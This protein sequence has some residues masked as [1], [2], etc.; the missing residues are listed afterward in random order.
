MPP[1]YLFDMTPVDLEH[2]RY[3]LAEVEKVNP[4]RGDMRLLD[5]VAW[6]SDEEP[7]GVAWKDVGEDE[8][9]V[10]G[11]IPGRPLF[12]GVL[13]LEAAAQLASFVCLSWYPE[14]TFMGFAGATDVKFRG[15]V[16]P[17]DRLILLGRQ[18]E[19]RHRRILCKTQGWVKG[20]L[21]FQADITGAPM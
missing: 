16:L 19:F 11:H 4:H 9:W 5:G 7:M 8:F 17:G 6:M 14:I 12:P 18:I 15:Q 21:V 2:P 13:Q 1:S 20:S 10:P 3:G